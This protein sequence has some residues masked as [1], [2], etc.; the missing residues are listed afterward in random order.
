MFLLLCLCFGVGYAI[1]SVLYKWIAR[2]KAARFEQHVSSSSREHE[3]WNTPEVLDGAQEAYYRKILDVSKSASEF[4]IQAS[5]RML[6][7]RYDPVRF[8]SLDDDFRNL[9]KRKTDEVLKAYEYFRRTHR[10][11]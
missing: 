10:L 1:V 9:A 8:L 4:E 11:P 7:A 2:R 3:P 6:L 5:Y